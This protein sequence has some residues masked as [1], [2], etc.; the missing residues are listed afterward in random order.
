MVLFV[1][2]NSDGTVQI[3]A[4]EG[5][6]RLMYS[7]NSFSQY[8]LNTPMFTGLLTSARNREAGLQSGAQGLGCYESLLSLIIW[9]IPV[10]CCQSKTAFLDGEKH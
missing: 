10:L 1:F 8:F 7:I 5:E 2:K 4:A 6:K 9:K 3:K